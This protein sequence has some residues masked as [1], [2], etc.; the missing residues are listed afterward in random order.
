M[1]IGGNNFDV[2]ILF[3]CVKKSS[4]ARFRARRTDRV[5]Q[6]YDVAFA[7]KLLAHFFPGHLAAFEIICGHEA[8]VFV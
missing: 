7:P 6:Q 3:E 4:F 8:D 2:R 5:T 1:L